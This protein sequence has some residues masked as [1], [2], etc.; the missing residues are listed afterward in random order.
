MGLVAALAQLN[1]AHSQI[2][3]VVRNAL[4]AVNDVKEQHTGLNGAFP[5]LQALGVAGA[6]LCL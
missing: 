5:G 3:A 6:Q 2:G 4:K 1:N